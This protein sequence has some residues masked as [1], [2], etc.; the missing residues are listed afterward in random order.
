MN[1][2]LVVFDTLRKDHV[3]AYGNDWVRTP[4]LDDLASQSVRCTRAF[5]EALPTLPFRRALHTGQ[6]TFPFTGHRDYKGDF[7]GAPGWGPIPE[8]QD[9]VSELLLDAGYRTALF[10]DCY[11]QFKPGKNFHRGFSEWQWI[12]GQE[13]DRFRSG[14]AL[15]DEAIRRHVPAHMPPA[16]QRREFFTQY[17][18]N[19][20]F[21]RDE[22]DYYP[23]RLFNGA[24]RW[25][26]ENRDAARFFLV[27]DSFDPHEPWEPPAD[28]RRMYDPDDDD[29]TDVIQSLY[30][31]TDGLLSER[32]VRRMQAN[33][34]GEVTL[35]D[36]WLGRFLE[37]L[38]VSGR[39]DDTLVI[40]VS[41]HGHNLDFPDDQG[42][43]SKQ[44]HPLTR[45]VAD[46]ALL[47]RF[48]DGARAGQTYDGLVTNTDVAATVLAAAGVHAPTEGRDLAPL[49]RDDLPSHR[50][51]VSIAW[52][53]LMTVVTDDWWCNASIWGEAPLLHRLPDDAALRQNVAAEHPDAAAELIGLAVADAGGAIPEQFAQFKN[54]P[55]CTP[56]LTAIQRGGDYVS[57]MR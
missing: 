47:V 22:S 11:H 42:L 48:P 14:P 43:I 57:R 19:N 44:G 2:V 39:A 24:S 10:T 36:R 55:G 40:V 15:P 18:T 7:S 5:P 26:Y 9:T 30:A 25:L 31:P 37:Q 52:G 49:L 54:R 1:V 34:A 6:R 16:H 50:Q 28:Y 12:R 17:L 46:L 56:Y 53:P 41:D 51:H 27:V 45:A 20:L 4:V 29:V 32:E 3:G 38:D 21:R 8:D 33:Y 35:C 23:A 13:T